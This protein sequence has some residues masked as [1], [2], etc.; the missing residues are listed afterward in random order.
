MCLREE[1][2]RLDTLEKRNG[3]LVKRAKDRLLAAEA[4]RI[5]QEEKVRAAQKSAEKRISEMQ[6]W[7]L[8]ENSWAAGLR[9]V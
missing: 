8:Q 4:R 1:Q 3:P 5:K 9:S 7:R 6:V 2:T